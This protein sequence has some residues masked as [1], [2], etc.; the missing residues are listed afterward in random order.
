MVNFVQQMMNQNPQVANN[1]LARELMGI[2][3]SGDESRGQQ[4]AENL[5]KTYG[6]N[7][8]DAISQARKYFNL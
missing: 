1:P 6:V 2:I 3:Q 8:N 5:C 4:I 7:K